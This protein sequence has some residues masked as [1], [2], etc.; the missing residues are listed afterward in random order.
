MNIGPVPWTGVV[1]QGV[2]AVEMSSFSGFSGFSGLG[3]FRSFR[4]GLEVF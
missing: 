1:V 4:G 3:P 2:V